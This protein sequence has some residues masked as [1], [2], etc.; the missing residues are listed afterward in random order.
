MP[1]PLTETVQQLSKLWDEEDQE[2]VTDLDRLID[3]YPDLRVFYDLEDAKQDLVTRGYSTSSA[4]DLLWD[5]HERAKF[6]NLRESAQVAEDNPYVQGALDVDHV[7]RLRPTIEASM[8]GY[9]L[10]TLLQ[11]S[12]VKQDVEAANPVVQIAVGAF[13]TAKEKLNGAIGWATQLAYGETAEELTGVSPVGLITGRTAK[14]ELIQR[15][16]AEHLSDTWWGGFGNTIGHIAAL[17]AMTKAIPIKNAG[18][19]EGIGGEALKW[20]L[21]EALLTPGGA[22]DR[23][24]AGAGAAF[25]GAIGGGVNK[26][27]QQYVMPSASKGLMKWMD[28]AI[29]AGYLSEAQARVISTA[30]LQEVL[31][32][33]GTTTAFAGVQSLHSKV[34]GRQEMTP[35]GVVQTVHEWN[36]LSNFGHNLM[37]FGGLAMARGARGFGAFRRLGPGTKRTLESE[38]PDTARDW[39]KIEATAKDIEGE[40]IRAPISGPGVTPR[41]LMERG[42]DYIKSK[43]EMP[44]HFVVLA[45]TLAARGVALSPEEAIRLVADRDALVE[46]FAPRWGLPAMQNRKLVELLNLRAREHTIKTKPG[47]E[48]FL[49]A[50]DEPISMAELTGFDSKDVTPLTKKWRDFSEQ[51]GVVTAM[52]AGLSREL[53]VAVDSFGRFVFPPTV[54]AETRA[55]LESATLSQLKHLAVQQGA[56]EEELPEEPLIRNPPQLRKQRDELIKFLQK[57]RKTPHVVHLRR[58]LEEAPRELPKDPWEAFDALGGS[59]NF[60]DNIKSIESATYYTDDALTKTQTTEHFVEEME[61]P[62]GLLRYT[63]N[64]IAGLENVEWVPR[65]APEEVEAQG[66]RPVVLPPEISMKDLSGRWLQDLINTYEKQGV[67]PRAGAPVID[68]E[69]EPAIG[70]PPVAMPDSH[71]RFAQK[72]PALV[73]SKPLLHMLFDMAEPSYII[74]AMHAYATGA[75]GELPFAA[76]AVL[77]TMQAWRNAGDLPSGRQQLFSVENV[78]AALKELQLKTRQTLDGRGIGENVLV[79]RYGMHDRTSPLTSVTLDPRVAVYHGSS[80]YT[81]MREQALR[82]IP[83]AAGQTLEAVGEHFHAYLVPKDAILYDVDLA[84]N[85][86]GEPLLSEL[87]VD[88][89]QLTLVESLK[90]PIKDPKNI[91]PFMPQSWRKLGA[92]ARAKQRLNKLTRQLNEHG[93]PVV[94]VG[95]QPALQLIFQANP[96]TGEVLAELAPASKAGQKVVDA[97]RAAFKRELKSKR[98]RWA[99]TNREI[100]AAIRK[101]GRTPG[102]LTEP[103][104]GAWISPGGDVYPM[105]HSDLFNILDA[106]MGEFTGTSEDFVAG[107]SQDVST[108]R[109]S[110]LPPAGFASEMLAS[111]WIRAAGPYDFQVFGLDR[112]AADA[113][114][115]VVDDLPMRRPGTIRV[116]DL[117]A[118]RSFTFSTQAYADAGHDILKA[119]SRGKTQEIEPLYPAFD[120]EEMLEVGDPI[121]VIKAILKDTPH[122]KK[123]IRKKVQREGKEINWLRHVVAWHQADP[124]TRGDPPKA[125]KTIDNPLEWLGLVRASFGNAYE[126]TLFAIENVLGSKS[127]GRVALYGKDPELVAQAVRAAVEASTLITPDAAASM[128]TY[129]TDMTMDLRDLPH[130]SEMRGVIKL[131]DLRDRVADLMSRADAVRRALDGII[132]T[133]EIDAGL[134]A[135]FTTVFPMKPGM[136]RRNLF[137]AGQTAVYALMAR[138]DQESEE[139]KYLGELGLRMAALLMDAFQKEATMKGSSRAH[140]RFFLDELALYHD[141]LRENAPSDEVGEMMVNQ[142]WLRVALGMEG[143]AGEADAPLN[144]AEI[145]F[146]W[147]IRR[148]LNETKDAMAL[149]GIHP[150]IGLGPYIPHMIAVIN[151]MVDDPIPEPQMQRLRRAYSRYFRQRRALSPQDLSRFVTD[152]NEILERY[153]SSTSHALANMP[154]SAAVKEI[155]DRVGTRSPKW[156]V[157]RDLGY[158]LKT[159]IRHEPVTGL[160]GQTVKW[161]VGVADRAAGRMPN[162]LDNAVQRMTELPIEGILGAVDLATRGHWNLRER[163]LEAH[164]PQQLWNWFVSGIYTMQLG[165]LQLDQITRNVVTGGAITFNHPGVGYKDFFRGAT[166]LTVRDPETGVERLNP[167][168]EEILGDDRFMTRIIRE[169]DEGSRKLREHWAASGA[170]EMQRWATA[171]FTMSEVAV[172][173]STAYGAYLRAIDEGMGEKMAIDYAR[174]VSMSTQTNYDAIVGSPILSGEF[175]KMVGQ[176]QRFN[177]NFLDLQLQYLGRTGVLGKDKAA[178]AAFMQADPLLYMKP[179]IGRGQLPGITSRGGLASAGLGL[180][181][182]AMFGLTIWGIGRTFDNLFEVHAPDSTGPFAPSPEFAKHSVN[183]MVNYLI[184]VAGPENIRDKVELA[185]MI[186]SHLGTEVPIAT[187]L[188]IIDRSI[189]PIPGVVTSGVNNFLALFEDPK[190]ASQMGRELEIGLPRQYMKIRAAYIAERDGLIRTRDNNRIYP[191]EGQQMTRQEL[192]R[193]YLGF[194]PSGLGQERRRLSVTKETREAYYDK[195]EF[196]YNEAK[197]DM[198]RGVD[199]DEVAGRW[200]AQVEELQTLMGTPEDGA[201][202]TQRWKRFLAE[203]EES[204]DSTVRERIENQYPLVDRPIRRSPPRPSRPRR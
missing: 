47:L 179:I 155:L 62:D 73:E 19:T 199:M 119:R 99:S 150:R 117:K 39:K 77:H 138:I 114:Q 51:R 164:V 57:S 115:S 157:D 33:A 158:R 109:E 12:N 141:M 80:D 18:I 196:I 185:H 81:L 42:A 178:A 97:L 67:V 128:R 129:F 78:Q 52:E 132:P 193:M 20:G 7:G 126:D 24:L 122:A 133:E 181:A 104:R 106:Q 144:N 14:E 88:P 69:R 95:R 79:F 2:Y 25:F 154:V 9:D 171:A 151:Q 90:L 137:Q 26:A 83:D 116:E 110:D 10:D 124:E 41:G 159:H 28:K 153:I 191:A 17:Y 29:G 204:Q 72:I 111:G 201:T 11:V 165:G 71:R 107:Q 32:V 127:A 58:I 166:G 131:P 38:F 15:W 192:V 200:W 4:A 30:A 183:A 180:L 203:A 169:V 143:R 63:W 130:P 168:I 163:A 70:A 184:K 134:E 174:Q 3:T 139:Q 108:L 147:G 13:H 92:L 56:T 65:A 1:N 74:G 123:L 84:H 36:F 121:G 120:T 94:S 148:L 113:I 167:K 68:P 82:A 5:A 190:L 8:A 85:E 176:F 189:G 198:V 46:A 21:S 177:L 186:K 182:L 53:S 175:G 101:A 135:A 140:A 146:S 156:A 194:T 105:E 142:S 102:R 86:L 145:M 188:G 96:V 195:L 93:I 103:D 66:Y 48:A 61:T 40:G 136:V 100:E 87:L 161:L 23:A 173:G 172:R 45:Q 152:F 60:G 202:L 16:E 112:R 98:E 75:Q 89:M 27:L 50:M 91:I 6:R 54:M 49:P 22:G 162:V 197:R 160:S 64:Q 34:V 149:Q 170:R 31:S 118:G 125:P 37:V 43:G 35:E 59:D 44:P 55:L 187:I 76:R